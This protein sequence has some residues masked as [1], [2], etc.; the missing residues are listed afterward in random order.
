MA[1]LDVGTEFAGHR[2]EATAG[3]GGMGIV[4]RALDIRLNRV[5]AMKLITP[6]LAQDPEFRERFERESQLAAS[7]DHTNVIPIHHAG[8]ENGVLYITM[9]YVQGTDLA[10]LIARDG[11]V[12][13]GRAVALISGVAGALDAAHEHGLIHRD[14]KPANI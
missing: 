7:I 12:D 13:P 10:A 9:R 1:E 8:E 2:I 3:R 11:R 14:V 4:Y 5:V 6:D